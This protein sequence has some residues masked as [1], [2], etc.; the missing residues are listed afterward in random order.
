MDEEFNKSEKNQVDEYNRG[1]IFYTRAM[2]EQRCSHLPTGINN[3]YFIH[4]QRENI[5]KNI[6]DWAQ[7]V[8]T[9]DI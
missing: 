8:D 6:I 2:Y 9:T 3:D 1:F 7:K 4:P 5:E